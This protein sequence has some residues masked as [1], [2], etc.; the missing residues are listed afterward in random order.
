M[1]T[2]VERKD[3]AATKKMRGVIVQIGSCQRPDQPGFDAK[4]G[5]L[6]LYTFRLDVTDQSG[7]LPETGFPFN[8]QRA[9]CGQRGKEAREIVS[10]I[11]SPLQGFT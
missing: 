10:G 7:R 2:A 9:E 1:S 3:F 11:P 4:A 5:Q 6:T 8:I